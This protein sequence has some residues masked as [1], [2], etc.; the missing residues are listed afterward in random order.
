VNRTTRT[1]LTLSSTILTCILGTNP[2]PL[3]PIGV[4]NPAMLA[5]NLKTAVDK[6]DL[7]TGENGEFAGKSVAANPNPGGSGRSPSDGFLKRR[8]RQT[9]VPAECLGYVRP[10]KA[11]LSTKTGL[12]VAVVEGLAP[13]RGRVSNSCWRLTSGA[14]VETL[15][16]SITCTRLGFERFRWRILLPETCGYGRSQTSPT[17][18]GC[19]DRSNVLLF[20]HHN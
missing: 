15:S 11:L 5:S 12:E 16:N 14:W 10:K 1:G 19:P 3:N 18:V 17:S 6:R 8:E 2:Y 7:S 4:R 13:H 9:Q 20:S